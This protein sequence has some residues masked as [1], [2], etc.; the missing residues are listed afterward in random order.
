MREGSQLAERGLILP[1]GEGLAILAAG[2]HIGRVEID[3]WR[4]DLAAAKARQCA[5]DAIAVRFWMLLDHDDVTFLRFALPGV[6]GRFARSS[7]KSQSARI[8]SAAFFALAPSSV[9]AFPFSAA[10]WN[11]GRWRMTAGHTAIL[12]LSITAV[13]S[14]IFPPSPALS[15]LLMTPMVTGSFSAATSSC[16]VSCRLPRLKRSGSVGQ[17]I[18]SAARITASAMSSS[19]DGESI[20]QS[21][22]PSVDADAMM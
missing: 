1:G 4:D 3:R 6:A 9:T 15:T 7:R 17:T 14:P 20:K 18:M 8:S 22:T 11:S 13:A 10:V 19:F 2:R 5:E 12:S 16:T 21:D